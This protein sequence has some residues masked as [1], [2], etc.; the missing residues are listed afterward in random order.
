[1]QRNTATARSAR[2]P[3]SERSVRHSHPPFAQL[4]RPRAMEQVR[5]QLRPLPELQVIP[6]ALVFLQRKSLAVTAHP[7]ETHQRERLQGSLHLRLAQR[8]EA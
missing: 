7:W 5:P 2:R 1:M 3:R 8:R 4:S 6:K